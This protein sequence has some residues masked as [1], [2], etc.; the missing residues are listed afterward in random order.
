MSNIFTSFQCWLGLQVFFIWLLCHQNNVMKIPHW[1]SSC[2]FFSLSNYNKLCHISLATSV[3]FLFFFFLQFCFHPMTLSDWHIN[4]HVWL[5]ILSLVNYTKRDS[6]KDRNI[7][8]DANLF[9]ILR[10]LT[11][12]FLKFP[13][14]KW[15]CYTFSWICGDE[16][17]SAWPRTDPKNKSWLVRLLKW[18]S[19]STFSVL[20]YS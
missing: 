12:C 13:S 14:V 7:N 3:F 8:F 9:H 11:I 6:V 20:S 5:Q 17:F 16:K 4:E 1:L 18:G 15:F 2:F 10:P 19:Q